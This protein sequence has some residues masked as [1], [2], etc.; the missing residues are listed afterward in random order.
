MKKALLLAAS[1]VIILFSSSCTK[2][3]DNSLTEPDYGLDRNVSLKVIEPVYADNLKPGNTYSIKWDVPSAIKN[4][5]LALYRKNV[6]QCDIATNIKNSGETTWSVP[7]GIFQS[8]HYT[9]KVYDPR[10]PDFYYAY[11]Q[12]FYVK[13]D[14]E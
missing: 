8:V 9:I 3:F 1:A 11:S 6:Y 2:H 5:T 13:A 10:F 7:Q 4:V 12:N 14:W